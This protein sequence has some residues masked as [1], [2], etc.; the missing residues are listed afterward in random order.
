MVYHIYIVCLL[1][2][3]LQSNWQVY[4]YYMVLVLQHQAV[5][6]ATAASVHQL[7]N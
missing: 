4:P 2:V 6:E 1:F 7:F 5:L 3:T